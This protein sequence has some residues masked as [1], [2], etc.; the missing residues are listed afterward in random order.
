[1]KVLCIHS[2]AIHGTASLKVMMRLL[3]TRLLPVASLYLSGLT[4]LKGV[5][6]TELDFEPLLRS[7][8]DIARQRG[9]R[10][11]V[12]IGYLGSASQAH[13]I[14]Q[15]LDQYQDLIEAVVVDPV[16]GDHGRTYVPETVWSAWPA[17]LARAD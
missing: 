16:S 1:M 7:S 9:E 13:L 14:E 15:C 4:N 3:G 12:Y 6:K 2:L 8:F 10:L 5:I 11:I 17:L